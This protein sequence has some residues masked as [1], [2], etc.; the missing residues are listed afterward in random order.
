MIQAPLLFVLLAVAWLTAG[1]M[2]VRTVS[3]IWLR[4]WAER[5][6]QGGG[7][8]TIYLERPQRLLASAGTGVAALLLIGG[9]VLGSEYNAPRLAVRLIGFAALVII[10]GQILAREIARRWPAQLAPF[11][12]PVLGG[13]EFVARPLAK[14]GRAIARRGPVPETA[15]PAEVSRDAIQD[16]LREGELEGVG[17]R[18]EIA[19]ISGVVEFSEKK[20]SEVMRP[21][22]EIFSIAEETPPHDLAIRIAQAGYSRVPV[23]RSSPDNVVGMVHAF[24]VLKSFG[25]SMPRI[26]PVAFAVP[27]DACNEL[28]FRMLRSRLHLA[29]IRD[30]DQ[31]VAGLVTLED[32]LEELVGDIRDEHDEPEPI[33]PGPPR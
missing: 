19:I 30:A 13:V 20:V 12:L 27:T 2:A 24:D 32:L 21:R 16:L 4:H 28:L 14:F 18:D 29:I 3:R 23:Y 25:E 5:R 15:D 33:R 11:L 1:G 7:A 10:V 6:L 26:R 8:A 31:R 22:G 17:E 9:M